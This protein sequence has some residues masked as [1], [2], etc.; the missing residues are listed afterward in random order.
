VNIDQPKH[1][2]ANPSVKEENDASP[3]VGDAPLPIQEESI[4]TMN[5]TQETDIRPDFNMN[6]VS[7][8]P[9]GKKKTSDISFSTTTTT[10]DVLYHPIS[11]GPR[12]PPYEQST[13]QHG[14]QINT[15]MPS[16][17]A[18]F[19][20]PPISTTAT[21]YFNTHMTL[22]E[23]TAP[24]TSYPN[25]TEQ[26]VF[27]ASSILRPQNENGNIDFLHQTQ[28]HDQPRLTLEQTSEY[29]HEVTSRRDSTRSVL[30]QLPPPIT[31]TNTVEPKE[32]QHSQ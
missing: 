26:T 15:I 12:A 25:H 5:S 17:E 21:N 30:E 1:E 2:N 31:T 29:Q 18:V 19:S 6:S 20:S 11:V 16:Q 23:E 24:P 3:I 10:N 8:L 28:E 13:A 32:Q 14:L 9:C 4:A 7:Q 22:R 27:T